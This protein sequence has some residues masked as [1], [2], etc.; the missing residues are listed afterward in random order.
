MNLQ[1]AEMNLTIAQKKLTQ[2][3]ETFENEQIKK[4]NSE[5]QKIEENNLKSQ[6]NKENTNSM[7]YLIELSIGDNGAV[8]TTM[9]GPTGGDFDGSLK[10]FVKDYKADPAP[11]PDDVAVGGGKKTN[12]KHK[13]TN[14]K[15]K[16][17]NKK[18][19][20]TN[21]KNK[22]SNKKHKKTNKK[23]KKQIKK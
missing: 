6:N 16:K 1:T 22:K 4:I 17:T 21:K 14:K 8:T 2:A 20:K 3:I 23:H 12:K 5:K 9:R 15:H 18:H 11:T 7:N 10:K 19:K 13:K